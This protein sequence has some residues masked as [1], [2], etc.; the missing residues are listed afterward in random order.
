MRRSV[1]AFSLPGS[2]RLAPR[3]AA[4]A[5]AAVL[6]TADSNLNPG[7]GGW[8]PT[9]NG[10]RGGGSHG[11]SPIDGAGG[12]GATSLAVAGTT[13]DPGHNGKGPGG[14][15][16]GGGSNGTPGGGSGGNGTNFVTGTFTYVPLAGYRGTDTLVYEGL[17]GTVPSAPAT[18]TF[19][20]G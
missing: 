17:H 19:V 10:G 2:R 9:G 12:G 18:V 16:G 3:L 8:S 14:G 13:V 6:A 7:P 1:D 15:A 5:D 11:A 4:V 20:I